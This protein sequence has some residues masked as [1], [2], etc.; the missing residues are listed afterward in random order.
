MAYDGEC[1]GVEERA[2]IR[3]GS[4]ESLADLIIDLNEKLSG[5]YSKKEVKNYFKSKN[6]PVNLKNMNAF[7]EYLLETYSW[8]YQHPQEEKHF[9]DPTRGTEMLNG[10]FVL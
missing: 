9:F 10:R 2:L 4:L 5:T 6:L 8:L 3:L 7:Y 1:I